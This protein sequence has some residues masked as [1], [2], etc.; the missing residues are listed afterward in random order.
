MPSAFQRKART[1]LTASTSSSQ[2]SSDNISAACTPAPASRIPT[3]PT[4]RPSP[5]PQQQPLPLFSL[6][7]SAINDVL[8]GVGLPSGCLS[9][10]QPLQS[11]QDDDDHDHERTRLE[12]GAAYSDLVL[13]YATAQ[14]IAH[15][16]RVLVVG[17]GAESWC[18]SLMGWAGEHEQRETASTAPAPTEHDQEE[19]DNQDDSTSLTSKNNLKSAFRYDKLQK[20]Q[21]RQGLDDPR[22]SGSGRDPNSPSHFVHP[23]DLTMRM[24]DATLDLAIKEKRLCIKDITDLE[25]DANS[26]EAVWSTIQ[27]FVDSSRSDVSNPEQHQVPVRIIIPS[28]GSPMYGAPSD[29]SHSTASYRLLMRVRRLV[30]DISW[31]SADPTSSYPATPP[32]PSI[33]LCTL[34]PTLLLSSPSVSHRLFHLSDATLAFSAFASDARLRAMFNLPDGLAESSSSSSKGAPS[35]SSSSTSNTFTGSL[36]IIKTPTVGSLRPS[37]IRASTLR[38]MTSNAMDTS[39]SGTTENSLGFKVRRKG[40]KVEVMGRDL[41]AGGEEGGEQAKAKRPE[42]RPPPKSDASAG[43]EESNQQQQ[44]QQ[45]TAGRTEAVQKQAQPQSQPDAPH[46]RPTATTSQPQLKGIAALRARGLQ[47]SG[48]SR[49]NTNTIQVEKEGGTH[50]DSNDAGHSDADS[51]TQKRLQGLKLAAKQ[52]W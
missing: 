25:A 49:S 7:L 32:V 30:R 6:G 27:E 50:T 15:G 10:F 8:T 22:A 2:P 18:R 36:K 9:I 40:F 14:G 26:Y 47:A 28:L 39:S 5:F 3:H 46:S 20:I 29:S 16:H 44:Q 52:D 48:A 11:G 24:S 43:K 45:E 51:A 1:F 37:S 23:F 31:P 35:S 4:L 34:S 21:A 13:K 38:G 12:A 19:Q 33:A 42:R 17:E 41:V